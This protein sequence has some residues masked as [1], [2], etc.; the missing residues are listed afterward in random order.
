MKDIKII[1]A[2]NLVALRKSKGLTQAEL[3]EK[4]NYSDKAICRWEHADTLP[5]INV[6]YALCDFYGITMNDLV[7]EDFAI[8]GADKQERDAIAYRNWACALLVA[9]VFLCATVFFI[10][11]VTLSQ[12]G[13][14]L[15][16]IW[17]VPISCIVVYKSLRRSIGFLMRIILASLLAWSCIT[18]FFL[19]VLLR[20][21]VN[22]WYLF[23]VGLPLQICIVLWQRVKRY[24]NDLY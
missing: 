4:F 10:V 18:G 23:L 15:A 21:E 7:N 24:K 14:W 19:H 11:T 20:L 5:D 2:Q 12:K 1:V 17:A 6:L 16:F 13:Y 3:A 8:E 9:V 22:I